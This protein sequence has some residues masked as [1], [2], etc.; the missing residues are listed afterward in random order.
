MCDLKERI[1]K[2][3]DALRRAGYE[4]FV[5]IE[6][7]HISGISYIN[8]GDAGI[9][10]LRDL[11][12]EG[13]R[14]RTFTTCNPACM[15]IEDLERDDIEARKQR[16]IV[17]ILKKIGVS[18]WLTCIPYEHLKIRQQRYYAWSESS[19]VAFISSIYDAYT[20]KLPGPLSLISALTGEMPKT[21][22]LEEENRYPRVLVEVIND[23]CLNTVEAGVLGMII[24]SQYRRKMDIPYV[25]FRRAPFRTIEAVKSFLASFATYS[26][27][28]L[29]IIEGLSTNYEKYRSRMVRECKLSIDMRD[30]DREVRELA[31]RCSLRELGKRTLVVTGCPHLSAHAVRALLSALGNTRLES[32]VWIFTSRFNKVVPALSGV[33]V[34]CDTCLF[35]SSYIRSIRDL[36]DKIYTT[37]IKQYYYLTKRVKDLEVRILIAKEIEETL[38]NMSGALFLRDV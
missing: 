11:H 37:S 35:V 9:E 33:R 3:K 19:A 31:T 10:L 36:S 38:N 15:C 30:I 22:I 4:D 14:T 26:N 8:V 13:L 32:N 27:C 23:R 21:E 7:A 16:E 5:K 34:I 25:R 28:P 1:K 29:V 17:H 6:T 20:D 18:T 24:G 2:L 12:R